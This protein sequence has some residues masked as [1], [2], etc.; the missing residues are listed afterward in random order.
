MCTVGFVFSH[1]YDAT[2]NHHWGEKGGIIS[3]IRN[4]IHISDGNNSSMLREIMKEFLLAK[5]NGFKFEPDLKGRSKT[6][7]KFIIDMDSQE[8]QI[9]SDAVELR[10]NM[11]TAW[12][13]VNDHMEVEELP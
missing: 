7:R 13:L 12:L 11:L 3:K 8:A 6:G 4:A 2:E 9:I 1:K 10:M 5:E